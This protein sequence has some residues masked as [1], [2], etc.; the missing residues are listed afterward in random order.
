LDI[1]YLQRLEGIVRLGKVNCQE[2]QGLCQ[3]AG[4]TGY[5]SIMFYPRKTPNAV[6]SV[7]GLFYS[8]GLKFSNFILIFKKC[9]FY[10]NKVESW[11]KDNAIRG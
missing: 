4:I 3:R 2:Q 5:P 11:R 6:N 9:A 10:E 7:G 8:Y 1:V